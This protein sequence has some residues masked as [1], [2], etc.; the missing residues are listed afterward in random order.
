MEEGLK[1]LHSN[2]SS[3][4]EKQEEKSDGK[5]QY[6]ETNENATIPLNVNDDSRNLTND[7]TVS[8]MDLYPIYPI[9]RIIFKN[10]DFGSQYNLSLIWKDMADELW[11]NVDVDVGKRWW[12][13]N[14]LEDLEYA[15][16]LASAGYITHVDELRLTRVDVSSI[17]VNIINSLAKIVDD[18]IQLTSVKGWRTSMLNDA[19]C[20]DLSIWDMK[21]DSGAEKRPIKVVND[22]DLENVTGDL[23]GLMES[24]TYGPVDQILRR[25]LVMRNLDISKVPGTLLHSFLKTFKFGIDLQTLTG[26]SSQLFNGI[27]CINLGFEDIEFRED[28][29][30][31]GQDINLD[32]ENLDLN[33]VSGNLFKVF[34]NI[35]HCSKL[36]LDRTTSS[37]LT[38]I[39]MTEIIKEKVESLYLI[40]SPMPDWLKQYDGDGKC[41][42]VEILFYNDDESYESWA[43]ARDWTVEIHENFVKRFSRPE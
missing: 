29:E 4:A 2:V 35:K 25:S 27:N 39:N 6:V 7:A 24:L 10:L 18:L 14:N 33:G 43:R 32:I 23:Q 15:G 5:T 28:P 11:R 21:L 38:N 8:F 3:N 12:R 34:E 1:N 17:P 9:R 19:N 31:I 40:R 16:V 26:I 30:D 22:V 13:I 36:Y 41:V 42:L 37:L 20:V